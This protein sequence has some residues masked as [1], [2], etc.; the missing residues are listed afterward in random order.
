MLAEETTDTQ[1]LFGPARPAD[2]I[3]LGVYIV[4]CLHSPAC[5]RAQMIVVL[6]LPRRRAGPLATRVSES[7]RRRVRGPPGGRPAP[8]SGAA[9]S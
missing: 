8:R 4:S 7:S 5:G 1:L 2:G 3:G 6:A 9:R